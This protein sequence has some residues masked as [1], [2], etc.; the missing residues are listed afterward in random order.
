MILI[1]ADVLGRERTGDETYVANLLRELPAAAPD[2]RFAAVTRHPEL[3]P[4]GV[5][6]IELPARSQELR[7]AWSL[8][9]LLRRLRPEL[10]HFQHAL[11]L[12][13]RGPLGRHA[14]RPLVRATTR[15]VMGL[16]RPDRRSGRSCRAPCAAPTTCS[17]SRSARS[18]TSSSCYGVPEEKVTVTPNGVDPSFAPGGD[19]DGGYLLFVGA[20][21]ARKNPLAAL[22]G[23]AG[24][25]PAARRRRA[26]RRTPALAARAAR[27]AAPTCAATSPRTSSP[28]STAA[29]RRS[30]CRRASRASGCRCSR[31]W[32]A[33]RR[34]SPPTSRRCARSPATRPSTPTDGDFA[35]AVRPRAAP[36]ARE[37]SRGRARAREGASPGRRPA[38]R[39][40]DVYRRVLAMKVAAVVVSHGARRRARARRCRRC[41]PQVDELVVIANVPGSV[42]RRRRGGRTTSGRSASPRTSTSASRCTTARL[43]VTANPTRCPSRAPSQRPARLHAETHERCGV[44]GPRM[45]FPDGSP[46]PSRRRFPTVGGTIVRRTPL[47][48]GRPAAPSLPPRRAAPPDEPVEAD[49]MLGGFLLLRR[50]MLDELGGFDEG[51]RLYGE[52]IDLAVPR[53]ARRLGALVRPAGGRPARAQGRDRQALADAAHAVALGG[54]RPL[55]AQAS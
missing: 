8:P 42:P 30:C 26:R 16:A 39:T 34:S 11:P 50:A 9:R 52:D 36:S 37:L 15:R 29:P 33:A 17:P 44:A 23:G 24:G 10:A 38:R 22:D 40:V 21:Q 41:A 3:V 32:P 54:H 5:E 2:L 35:A 13:W 53:D 12:G 18:A 28:S 19:V 14:A 7:M 46:Q 27:A 25:R 6:P 43:I 47:R 4:D 48:Q 45:V 31:R 1:D 55:R 51:F 49:W 20:I